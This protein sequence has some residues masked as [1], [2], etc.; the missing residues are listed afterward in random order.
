MASPMPSPT[1]LDVIQTIDLSVTDDMRLVIEP[2]Q[3]ARAD[4]HNSATFKIVKQPVSLDG[5][6]CRAEVKNTKGTNHRLVVNGEFPLTND[7][8]VPGIGQLQL[9]YSDGADIVRKT[10]AAPFHVSPS[11]N[12]VDPSDPEFENG[13]AQIQ[14]A[15]FT[16]VTGSDTAAT[17][18]NISGHVVATLDYPPGQGGGLDEATANT[19]YLRLTGL[20]QMTGNLIFQNNGNGIIFNQL[21]AGAIIYQ[22]TTPA[23]RLRRPTGNAPITIED[24]SGVET[25]RSAIVTENSGDARYVQRTGGQMSGSLIMQGGGSVTNAQLALGDNAT[26]F[27]RVG[28][29]VVL[30]VGGQVYA[31]WLGTPQSLMMTVPLNM[32]TQPINN[33]ADPAGPADAVNLRSLNA[34]IAALPSAPPPLANRAYIPNEITLSSAAQIFFDQAFPLTRSGPATILV[35]AYLDFEGGTPGAF[36]DLAYTCSFA[37]GVEEHIA[38]YLAGTA[39]SQS[40]LKAPV[41]FAQTIASPGNSV[42]ITLSARQLP[43]PTG[44]LVQIGQRASARS[45]VTVTEMTT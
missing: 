10:Y 20:N 2:A 30:T 29:T 43:G 38:V 17:F 6:V 21:Q 32:A 11:I 19:L 33:L 39:G 5:Y 25:S 28:T 45:Y 13:L 44:A 7:I 41:V 18:T 23:L 40:Y 1:A 27:Y 42:Q 34:A 36:Y 4:E 16:G 24:A 14:Q 3:I 15:A 35:V 26:G 9:V 22:D 12:A 8:A 31:Q 37:A